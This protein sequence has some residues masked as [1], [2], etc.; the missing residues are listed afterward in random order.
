MV[1]HEIYYRNLLPEY[2]GFAPWLPGS[3]NIAEVGYVAR[4]KWIRLFDASKEP[5]DDRNRLGIPDNY[6]PLVIGEVDR[7]TLCDARPFARECGRALQYEIKASGDMPL[8]HSNGQYL[9]KS[10]KRDGAILVPRDIESQDVLEK[11]RFMEYIRGNCA[12]WLDFANVKHSRCLRLI[13]LVLVTGWH[14]TSSWACAAFSD[15]SREVSLE[16]NVDVGGVAGGS[17]WATWSKTISSGVWGHSGPAP[18]GDESSDSLPQGDGGPTNIEGSSD[19]RKDNASLPTSGPELVKVLQPLANEMADRQGML[20]VNLKRSPDQGIFIRGFKVCDKHTALARIH[21]RKLLQCDDG[22]EIFKLLYPSDVQAIPQSGRVW[23]GPRGSK[24]GDK[25]KS[26]EG[27]PPGPGSHQDPSSGSD[28]SLTSKDNGMAQV[29]PSGASTGS[30]DSLNSA[31]GLNMDEDLIGYLQLNCNKVPTA[32]EITLE[33]I[34]ENS[35][36]EF[37]IAHDDDVMVWLKSECAFED[38]FSEIRKS[39]PH[40]FLVDQ[41]GMLEMSHSVTLDTQSNIEHEDM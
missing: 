8:T 1:Y 31:L 27:K 7:N 41:V 32:V 22:F 40:I 17:L 19:D 28:N 6:Y 35:E 15:C 23:G 29:N 16:L 33:Y 38:L 11:S 10:P 36:A 30:S 4:G 18:R 14:K 12:S 13:D 3:V 34:L 20:E 37:A 24:D 21:Y 39:Q 5:G 2:K 25:D 9:F 26:G